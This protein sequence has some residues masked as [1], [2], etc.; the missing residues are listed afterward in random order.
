MNII[1]IGFRCTGKTTVGRQLAQRLRMKFVDSDQ[2]LEFKTGAVISD[3][4]QRKGESTFRLLE[5]DALADLAKGDNQVLATG[6]G[7][8]LR[9]K[10]IHNLKRNGIII[11]LEADPRSVFERILKDPR[12]MTQRP[13]LNPHKDPFDEVQE[14]MEFRR[15]YYLQAADIRIRTEEKPADDVVGELLA[16]L[17]EWGFTPPASGTDGVPVEPVA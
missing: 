6:G 17:S 11:L 9:Y 13:R 14:Q 16:R 4:W 15:P 2:Y 12:S 7:A 3:L 8:V 5:A 1:L 10:N